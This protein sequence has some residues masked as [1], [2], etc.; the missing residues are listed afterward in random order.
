MD[1]E[2]VT[3]DGKVLK[4]DSSNGCTTWQ[5]YTMSQIGKLKMAKT[6]SFTLYFNTNFFLKT[7]K[8]HMWKTQFNIE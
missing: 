3:D 5:M 6:V 1:T 2:F 7:I 8:K 4:V